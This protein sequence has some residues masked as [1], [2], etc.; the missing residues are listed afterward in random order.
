MN[1]FIT[2]KEGRHTTNGTDEINNQHNPELTKKENNMIDDMLIEEYPELYE[3]APIDDLIH[4]LAHSIL[5][6]GSHEILKL[7][8][9]P[10]E[11]KIAYAIVDDLRKRGVINDKKI[12][13]CGL[14][15][16]AKIYAKMCDIQQLHFLQL[17]NNIQKD[18]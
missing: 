6:V 8:E 18:A 5:E 11:D 14:M 2:N 1:G 3:S 7:M 13:Y 16:L 4:K 17:Y 10:E 12:L 9:S 15:K